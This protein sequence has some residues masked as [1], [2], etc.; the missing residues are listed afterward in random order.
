MLNENLR[1][2][3]TVFLNGRI[4]ETSPIFAETFSLNFQAK[5]A[6]IFKKQSYA[7]DDNIFNEDDYGTQIFFIDSGRVSVMHKKT[8]TFI[9]ELHK[10]DCFGEISFFS[11]L[12]R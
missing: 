11:D 4:L 3:I 2:K 1:N 7:V 9:I 10:D 8:L 5:I 12:P 6:F